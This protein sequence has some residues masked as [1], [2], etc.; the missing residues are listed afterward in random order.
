VAADE[1]RV[2]DRRGHLGLRGAD[3]GDDGVGAD[4]L[5]HLRDRT[6]QRPDGHGD[7]RDVDVQRAGRGRGRVDRAALAGRL[8]D[9]RDV[10]ADDVRA[11][12]LARRQADA[13]A[14]E[15][16]PGDRDPWGRRVAQTCSA[17]AM[18]GRLPASTAACS[19]FAA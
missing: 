3:V 7:D 13:A 18:N 16:D 14:D 12:A 15:P 17:A 2:V 9:L 8:E 6:G 10:E 11:Q 5:E 4:P 19:T 1:A